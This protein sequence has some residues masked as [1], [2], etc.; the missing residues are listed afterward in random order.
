MH[1]KHRWT[2][3]LLL[4]LALALAACTPTDAGADDESTAPSVEAAPVEA[5]QAAT[6]VPDPDEY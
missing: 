5:S 4:A 1:M 2:G 3:A 6:P